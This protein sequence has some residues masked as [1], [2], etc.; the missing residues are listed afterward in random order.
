MIYHLSVQGRPVPKSRPRF[1]RSGH[2]YTPPRTKEYEAKVK[3]E[4]M[5]RHGIVASDRPLKVCV[6][7]YY[8]MPKS[9]SK[10]KKREAVHYTSRP[11]IDNLNKAVFDALNGVAY[12][13]DAQIV[14]VNAVKWYGAEDKTEV[15]IEEL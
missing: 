14:Q 13:D 5:Y 7:Y 10:A 1:T 2:T 15:I 4:W 3:D 6:M 12:L 11:D 9:W 8:S